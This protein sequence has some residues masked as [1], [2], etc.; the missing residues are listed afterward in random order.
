MTR[1]QLELLSEAGNHAVVRMPGRQFP[2]SVIQGDSLFVLCD[3]ARSLSLCLLQLGITD[4]ETLSLAQGLQEQLLDRL[5]H[6][7]QTLAAHNLALPY[8]EP[9]T[10]R[11][12]VP[13]VEE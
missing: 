10:A 5:I 8:S 1:V 12:L 2:G 7:Q 3:D 6:Y 13:L 4:E 11:D 9:A